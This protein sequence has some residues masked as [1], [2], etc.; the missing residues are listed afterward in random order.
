[1]ALVQADR[2]QETSATTGTGTLDLAG[3]VSGFKTFV[4]GIGDTNE[5][6]YAIVSDSGAWEVGRGTVAD[7]A[8]DTLTRDTVLSNSLGTTALINFTGTLNVFTTIPADA[9]VFSDGTRSLDWSSANGTLS[10]LGSVAAGN[11]WNSVSAV[12]GSVTIRHENS[13]AG[14]SAIA[15]F[16][17]VADASLIQ[18]AVRST[19]GNGEGLFNVNGGFCTVGTGTANELRWRTNGQYRGFIGATGGFRLGLNAPAVTGDG[20]LTVGD[21]TTNMVF[22]HSAGTLV[23]TSGVPTFPIEVTG[24]NAAGG[25]GIQVQN[26]SANAAAFGV[27]NVKSDVATAQIFVRSAAGPI[28]NEVVY[29]SAAGPMTVG[30]GDAQDLRFRSSGVIRITI[31]ANGDT[32]FFGGAAAAQPTDIVALTDSTGGSSDNTVAAVSGSG[33]D[34]TINNNFADLIAKVNGLRTRLRAVGLMA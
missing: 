12:N 24:V 7:L 10:N 6:Y 22:D 23:V 13:D 25:T 28:A 20:D 18:M 19:A 5:C 17:A 30:P 16:Q 26:T 11:R 32:G 14:A 15:D 9:F 34:A 4:A 31:A 27:I 1:M 21:A 3:A 8:T 2:V 33:D 29:T